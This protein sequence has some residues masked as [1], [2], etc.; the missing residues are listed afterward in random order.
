MTFYFLDLL[1][2]FVVSLF[3]K[4]Q[5]HSTFIGKSSNESR[6]EKKKITINF[7]KSRDDPT[8]AYLYHKHDLN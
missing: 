8:I 6:F 5:E 3:V 1:D 2:H 7:I 4:L